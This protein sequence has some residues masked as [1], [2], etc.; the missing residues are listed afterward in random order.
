M[1]NVIVICIQHAAS[2]NGTHADLSKAEFFFSIIIIM[3]KD[4]TSQA[5]L[6]GKIFC[7]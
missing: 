5:D 1:N 3:Y 7:V 4:F 2:Q 6:L